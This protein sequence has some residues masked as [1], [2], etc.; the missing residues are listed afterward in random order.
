MSG[1]ERHGDRQRRCERHDSHSRARSI[2]Q[3]TE[4]CIL[5]DSSVRIHCRSVAEGDIVAVGD[6]IRDAT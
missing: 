3:T 1:E 4:T 5:G 2:A 6:P